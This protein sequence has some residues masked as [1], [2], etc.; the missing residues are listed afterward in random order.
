MHMR[1]RIALVP[2]ALLLLLAAGVFVARRGESARSSPPV[3]PTP[4]HRTEAPPPS[5]PVAP[6]ASTPAPG[7]AP[8]RE[9][10][11][12]RVDRLI[13]RVDQDGAHLLLYSEGEEDRVFL[14]EHGAW[15]KEDIL[16]ICRGRMGK[17][18][19]VQSVLRQG[20]TK[21]EQA[22][23]IQELGERLEGMTETFR[24]DPLQRAHVLAR[25]AQDREQPIGLR[26]D[27]VMALG[28]GDSIADPA[29]RGEALSLLDRLTEPILRT[30]LYLILSY[31]PDRRP[32]VAEAA[33][34]RSI[35]AIV[36]ESEPRGTTVEILSNV[37]VFLRD[38]EAR[39]LRESHGGRV[40]AALLARL[41]REA[42]REEP[43]A[44]VLGKV[45]FALWGRT[46]IPPPEQIA[47]AEA[48]LKSDRPA[49]VRSA[50]ASL[51]LPDLEKRKDDPAAAA[52]RSQSREILI[53]ALRGENDAR[54][55]GDL[56]F[57]LANPRDPDTAE[58]LRE[59]A[60]ER[61]DLRPEI[62]K[63]LKE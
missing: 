21:E 34:E 46:T 7:G 49:A 47:R 37:A 2:L 39:S 54:V 11:L 23:L 61:P 27:A 8:T 60:R 53:G 41:E 20:L 25:I 5:V 28:G 62:L 31:R 56:L 57:G 51:L 58:R 12:R 63:S 36:R 35:D 26:I 14:K 16:R 50:A 52:F 45:A 30:Q 3:L 29:V 6:I 43:D 38:E 48:L 44:V 9:E 24:K 55:R 15:F 1:R 4:A 22:S 19:P 13:R 33:L 17:F 40:E 42:V 32:G 59:L 18:D 10:F